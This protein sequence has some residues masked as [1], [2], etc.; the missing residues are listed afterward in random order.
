MDQMYQQYY[1]QGYSSFEEYMGQTEEEY[2]ANLVEDS[3]VKGTDKLA[4]QAILENEGIVPTVDDLKA[5]FEANGTMDSFDS[6]METYGQ[7]Y[8]MLDVI[9]NKAIQIAKDNAVVK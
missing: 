9:K 1:G 2:L 7:G 5:Q 8:M 6:S 3:K 4:Y